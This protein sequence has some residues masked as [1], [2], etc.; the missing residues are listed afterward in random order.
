MQTG[1][2]GGNHDEPLGIHSIGRVYPR[3][4]V[5]RSRMGTAPLP[6][7]IKAA[8]WVERADIPAGSQPLDIVAE[9]SAFDRIQY[10]KS[11]GRCTGPPMRGDKLNVALE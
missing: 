9:Y 2:A 3:S 4:A 6:A 7:A 11:R 8:S 1:T 5:E 10:E